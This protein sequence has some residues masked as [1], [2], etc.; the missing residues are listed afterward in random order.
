MRFFRKPAGRAIF[1]TLLL[2]VA[3]AACHRQISKEEKELRHDLHHALAT[4]SYREAESLARHALQYAPDDNGLW[5]RLVQA[6]CGQ[7]NFKGVKESFSAWRNSVRNPSSKLDE[8]IGDV[9]LAEKDAGAALQ[10]WHRLLG[11]NPHHLRVLTKV[12]RV[13]KEQRHWLE[14]ETAWSEALQLKETAEGR[15]QRAQCRRHLHRWS[16]TLADLQRAKALA[17]N[18]PDVLRD[19]QVFERLSKFLA[20]IRSLDL[21]VAA[22]PNDHV[23]LADRSLLFL[24]SED[25]E[26]AL[27]DAEASIKLAPW[28]T[29]P[30]LFAGIALLRLGRVDEVEKRS[31][32]KSFRIAT[33]TPEFLETISRLDSE[34]SVEPKNSELYAT[35]AWYLNDIGQPELALQDAESAAQLD[36]KSAS[37][38]AEKSYA[39]MKI[40]HAEKAFEEIQHATTLD[41]NYATAWQY[42]GELEMEQGNYIAA[43]ESLSRALSLDQTAA[44]L[45]K[46]EACYRQLG[47]SSKAEE[48][49]RI[50]QELTAG[51]PK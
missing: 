3:P 45:A 24:R 17:P 35:R 43:V 50:L 15:V 6:Q 31:I 9:A 37:A 2:A 22:S 11:R 32:R 13:E 1:A 7:A 29:R 20:E 42:R 25:F 46:R 44:A 41:P 49:H 19:T 23:L 5:D 10:A 33:L 27:E 40:G 21:Q 26:L 16:E 30:K 39:L 51:N 12:A 18:D 28:V 34:I 36:P 8:Y 4:H 14:A 48:D 38:C 47:W